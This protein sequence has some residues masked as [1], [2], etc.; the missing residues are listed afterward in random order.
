M[1]SVRDRLLLLVFA[2]VGWALCGATIA[3]SRSFMPM[4][5][6]LI[7]H[8]VAAPILAASL[9]YLHAR[10]FAVTKPLV[11][12]AVFVGVMIVMDAGLVA[13]FLEKSWSMFQSPLGTWIPFALTFLAAWG[14]GCWVMGPGPGWRWYA[15]RAERRRVLPGDTLV[16]EATNPDTRGITIEARPEQLWPWLVQMGCDRA[17]W[18][19][20]DRLDNAG[21]PSAERIIPELQDVEVGDILPSRPG[22]RDAF[23]VLEMLA[24]ERL[25][26]GAS[27]SMPHGGRISWTVSPPRRFVRASWAFILDR[28]AVER[29][30]LL[31]RTRSVVRPLWLSALMTAVFGPAHVI[32]QRKQLLNLKAR[33]ERTVPLN[34]GPS[35]R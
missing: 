23:D 35:S 10:H 14:A 27:L 25:V 3:V 34:A 28:P 26:L 15:T 8:A 7:V 29:T 31:V 20:W 1:S 6:A 24:P 30:R 33:A 2:L 18:Y 21:R 32:M 9:A 16:P 13:P 17:G 11:A 12:A 22:Y 19:S 5:A 4:D